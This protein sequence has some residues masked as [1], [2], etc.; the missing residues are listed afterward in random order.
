M[1]FVDLLA[2]SHESKAYPQRTIIACLMYLIAGGKDIMCAFQIEY[3]E[4]PL[5]FIKQFPIPELNNHERLPEGVLFYN[6]IIQ[7]FFVNE[8]GFYL[9]DLIEPLKFVLQYLVHDISEGKQV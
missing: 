9:H 6:Q 4:M 8:F 5:S 7:P 2:I 3:K 1:Q